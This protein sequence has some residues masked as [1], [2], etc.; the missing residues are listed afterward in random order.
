M[1][2]VGMGNSVSGA[3]KFFIVLFSIVIF[4]IIAAAGVIVAMISWTLLAG[5][6]TSL[7][8][9]LGSYTT[10]LRYCRIGRNWTT[11][12]INSQSRPNESIV[13]VDSGVEAMT[14][15]TVVQLT[16]LPISRTVNLSSKVNVEQVL[17]YV[18]LRKDGSQQPINSSNNVDS[19]QVSSAPA[20][21]PYINVALWTRSNSTDQTFRQ[22]L[23][24]LNDVSTPQII[25]KT[26]W[27]PYGGTDHV[28]VASAE[29]LDNSG[30]ELEANTETL[31]LRVYLAGYC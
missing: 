3:K 7:E 5:E 14:P 22:Y 16:N 1:T 18:I 4:L 17:L 28:L 31:Q 25:S 11:I 9:E 23:A 6:T 8:K 21:T 2:K 29:L 26:L 19:S 27:F 30:S 20:P 10:A 15:P 13:I 24:I 12:E